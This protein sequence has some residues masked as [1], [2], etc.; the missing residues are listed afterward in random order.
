MSY[1]A[2]RNH[3]FNILCNISLGFSVPPTYHLSWFRYQSVNIGENDQKHCLFRKHEISCNLAGS[4][5][6][7]TWKF[8]LRLLRQGNK[9]K[10]QKWGSNYKRDIAPHAGFLQAWRH[11][12]PW[13]ILWYSHTMKTV[14]RMT[15]SG[16]KRRYLT[17]LYTWQ[18]TQLQAFPLP[19]RTAVF[20]S[21]AQKTSHFSLNTLQWKTAILAAAST[22]LVLRKHQ[23]MHV[24][25]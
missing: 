21:K 2:F 17:I 1:F 19:D 8:C 20:V 3:Y 5:A 14:L 25:Q 22:K 15:E 11:R 12:T 6:H 4:E 7:S 13:W 24:F 23:K 16:A 9:E 10:K 18:Y